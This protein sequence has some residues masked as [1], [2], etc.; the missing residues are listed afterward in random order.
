MVLNKLLVK[1]DNE[2]RNT[3]NNDEN[4]AKLELIKL[5]EELVR[6]KVL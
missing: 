4:L 3:V 5:H 1:V 2:I 6:R